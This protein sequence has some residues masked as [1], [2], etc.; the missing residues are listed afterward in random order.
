MGAPNMAANVELRT[1]ERRCI[2]KT[3]RKS[4][5]TGNYNKV[6]DVKLIKNVNS[7]VEYMLRVVH[8]YANMAV[9]EG[10]YL[11]LLLDMYQ[12]HGI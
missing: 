6:D 10:M 8:F 1:L 11:P 5:H 12:H 9:E 3:L 2:P 4:E 7:Y